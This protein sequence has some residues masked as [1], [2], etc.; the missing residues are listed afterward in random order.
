MNKLNLTKAI[1]IEN[2]ESKSTLF[3]V[4]GLTGPIVNESCS[5]ALTHIQ[6]G[7]GV[8]RHKHL[9]SEETYIFISG[10]AEMVVNG[11]TLAVTAGDT[12]VIHAGDIHELKQ[13]GPE[14]ID[15]YAITI[16]PYVEE[17]FIVV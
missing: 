4:M 11:E 3:E 15:F 1:K 16:P 2:K 10:S 5:I 17:D 8:I 9:E 12:V 13:V 7:G 14:G 6:P